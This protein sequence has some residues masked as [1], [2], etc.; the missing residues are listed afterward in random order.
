M[1][2]DASS[3]KLRWLKVDSTAM[4]PGRSVRAHCWRKVAGEL[5]HW[6]V[7]ALTIASSD[8]SGRWR[9][10]VSASQIWWVPGSCGAMYARSH[11]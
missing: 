2:M 1:P 7:D 3:W 5:N 9:M 10:A 6:M 8:A 4:P 11:S